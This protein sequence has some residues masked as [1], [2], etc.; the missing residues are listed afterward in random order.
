MDTYTAI[1][2]RIVSED[3][4]SIVES[5]FMPCG[6]EC[7]QYSVI[8]EI[9]EIERQTIVILVEWNFEIWRLRM[10]GNLKK[11]Q[12]INRIMM[13]KMHAVCRKYNITYYYDSGALIGAV[14]HHSFIPWDVEVV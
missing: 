3:V 8:G 10:N 13:R 1:S 7:D 4:L 5:S 2:R 14:R 11:V 9:L 6:V 12:E